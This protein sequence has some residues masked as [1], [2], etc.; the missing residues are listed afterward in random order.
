MCYCC[1][2]NPSIHHHH[3]HVMAVSSPLSHHGVTFTSVAVSSL[4]S[5]CRLHHHIVTVSS[6]QLRHCGAFA[7]ALLWFCHCHH[8]VTF[9]ITILRCRHRSCI[10]VVPLLSHRHGFVITVTV[11]PSSLHRHGFVV[12]V[13]L[14]S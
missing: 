9:I 4:S 11:L 12:I 3:R 1:A 7:V 5:R 6:S 2:T 13:V 8:G 10:V 14:P